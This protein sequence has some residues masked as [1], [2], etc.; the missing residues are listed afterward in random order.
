M[1]LLQSPKLLIVD[2]DPRMRRMIREVLGD[3]GYTFL[4]GGDG[5]EALSLYREHKPSLVLL[6]LEMKPVDGIRAARLI[7]D[8]DPSS[9]VVMLSKHDGT[10]FQTAAAEAGVCAYLLKD[11]LNRLPGVLA[12]LCSHTAA[13][14]T[15][16]HGQN[17]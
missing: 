2:D 17:D 11:Q 6:D 14:P 16:P 9:C 1:P 12:S 4:E 8:E 7:H 10:R 5:E 3:S 15:H 13:E